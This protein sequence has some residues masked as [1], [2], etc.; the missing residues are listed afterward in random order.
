MTFIIKKF[1]EFSLKDFYEIVKIREEVFI[2]EQTCV[3]QECDGKDQK[4]FHLVCME[5][6]KVLAYLRILERGL[7]FDEI[8]IGRVLVKREYRGRGLAKKL[9]EK[10]LNFIE[11]RLNENTIRISAQEYLTEFYGSFGFK[12][13]SDTYLEDGIPH[14]EM[15][16]TKSK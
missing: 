12:P 3:Y 10:A 6:S 15:L 13:V 9:I 4:A 11:D 2:V 8:S 16:Y 5:D 1:E 7:S 14:V